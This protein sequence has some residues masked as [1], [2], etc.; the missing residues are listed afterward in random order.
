MRRRRCPPGAPAGSITLTAT[1]TTLPLNL[2]C[3]VLPGSPFVAEI[4]FTYRNNAGAITALTSDATFTTSS[5]ITVSISSPD[6][7]STDD[8]YEPALRLVSFHDTTNNGSYVFFAT[9]FDVAGTSTITASATDPATGLTV[10]KSL[11]FTVQGAPPLPGSINLSSSPSVVYVAGTGGATS[12]VITALMRDG[13]NQLVPDPGNV[14]N[15]R[16]E[17][18]D[19]GVASFPV[20]RQCAAITRDYAVLRGIFQSGLPPAFRYKS[21]PRFIARHMQQWHQ[22]PISNDQCC[23]SWQLLVC[24]Y[25]PISRRFRNHCSRYRADGN[26]WRTRGHLIFTLTCLPRSSS[27]TVSGTPIQFGVIDAPLSVFREPSWH[28]DI[29]VETAPLEAAPRSLRP[30]PLHHRGGAAPAY[31]CLRQLVTS[32]SVSKCAACS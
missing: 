12:S 13:A 14:D 16:Y 23:S 15:V 19:A 30:P 6:D 1:R 17:F 7:P 5:P 24:P 11:V 22:R 21:A 8:I 20:F 32:T 28:F 31:L 10:S 3:P 2:Q 25:S 4:A 29:A 26:L 9:S 27:N 18:C